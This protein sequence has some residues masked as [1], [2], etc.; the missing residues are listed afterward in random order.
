PTAA[1][2]AAAAP[3]AAWAAID[4]KDLLLLAFADGQR[5]AIWLAAEF[6]PAH[7]ANIRTIARSGWWGDATVYRVQDNYVTQWG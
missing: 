5:S 7:I 3:A 6:A 2:L 1:Q 4:P